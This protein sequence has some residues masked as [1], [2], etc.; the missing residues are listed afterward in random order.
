[1]AALLAPLVAAAPA[2]ARLLLAPKAAPAV[3]EHDLRQ[4]ALQRLRCLEEL[5]PAET[6]LVL[7]G[8]GVVLGASP[9]ARRLLRLL[10]D[11]IESRVDSVFASDDAALLLNAME[12]CAR[13]E[14]VEV[15]LAG[16]NCA[17][18]LKATLSRCSDDTVAVRLQTWRE[19][20]MPSQKVARM[21]AQAAA[22]PPLPICDIGEALGFTLEHL[23]RK[24]EARSIGLSLNVEAG[25]AAVCDIQLGRRILRGVIDA[26]IKESRDD[27]ELDISARRLRSVVLI[28]AA[29]RR[30]P[31]ADV[32]SD[33]EMSGKCRRES[34]AALHSLAEAAGGTL[35]VVREAGDLT[36]TVRL[37]A[38][39]KT[40]A[41][42]ERERSHVG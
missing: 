4:A 18:T 28:R 35:V 42:S 23:R 22:E 37:P 15:R 21:E 32:G 13:G 10:P 2:I 7:D 16:H 26:A 27:T 24:A 30:D 20:L 11:A 19:E 3:V 29:C 14:A 36:F 38:A 31:A 17:G 9:A 25:A 33:T 6:M 8:R 41:R 1:V 34:D 39:D 12:R 5:A 40:G